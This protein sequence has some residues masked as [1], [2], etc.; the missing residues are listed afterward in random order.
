MQT[1]TYVQNILNAVSFKNVHTIKG[2]TAKQKYIETVS[3]L[4]LCPFFSLVL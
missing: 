4:P 2:E 3:V 1:K